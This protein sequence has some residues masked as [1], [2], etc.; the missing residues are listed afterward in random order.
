MASHMLWLAQGVTHR[1]SLQHLQGLHPV[2]TAAH[3]RYSA[4]Q[5]MIP[6]ADPSCADMDLPLLLLSHCQLLDHLCDIATGCTAR[7]ALC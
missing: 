4:Q 7:P 5:H 2:P 6:C 3:S 1:K